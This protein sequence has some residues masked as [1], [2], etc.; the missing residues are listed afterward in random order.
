MDI[1]QHRANI[2]GAEA[3]RGIMEVVESEIQA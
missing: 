3:C 1:F 2:S